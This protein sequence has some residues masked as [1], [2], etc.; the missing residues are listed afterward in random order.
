[1]DSKKLI[2]TPK[3]KIKELLDAYPELE[4]VLID[5]APAFKKLKNPVLRNTIARVTTLQQAALVGDISLDVII[6]KLRGI[7]GQDSLEVENNEI[8]STDR[9]DW[10]S[11]SRVIKQ[12]DARELIAS[13]GHPLTQVMMET[14]KMKPGEVYLLIVPFFP[15]PLVDKM[16]DQGWMHYSDRISNELFYIYFMK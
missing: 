2:I 5:I 10:A 15:A 16:K 12:L 13:G 8:L 9:P 14:M 3:T 1:M 6:N 4:A 11:S 7:T